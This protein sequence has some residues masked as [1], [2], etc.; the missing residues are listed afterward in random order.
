MTKKKKRINSR[1]KGAEYERKTAKV[2][3]EW[4]GEDFNRTPAS[5]GLQWGD[6]NRVT[7]DIVTP[8]DSVFPFVIECK[9][10]EEWDFS[11]LLRDTGEMEEWWE[12]VIRDSEKV[13]LRPF[14]IFSRNYLPD[15]GMMKA[16]DF[17]SMMDES[18]PEGLN[19]FTLAKTGYEDRV[20]FILEEF[21][22]FVPKATI[23]R[24]YKL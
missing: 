14:L 9:K 8:V 20:T 2:L 6:D 11:Q 7:G 16:T 3:G 1:A 4:W 5:G 10:R 24:N 15:F 19:F 12:Q 18:V 13:S 17:F 22:E 21:I 23:I